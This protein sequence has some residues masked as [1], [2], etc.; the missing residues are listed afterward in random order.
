M[1]SPA[2]AALLVRPRTAL[3]MTW[4]QSFFT[5]LVY[6]AVAWLVT[7]HEFFSYDTGL[8]KYVLAGVAVSAALGSIILPFYLVSDAALAGRLSRGISVEQLTERRR[9]DFE[10][11]DRILALTPVDRKLLGLAYW[12]LGRFVFLGALCEAVAVIGLAVA[13]LEHTFYAVIPF[14]AGAAILKMTNRPDINAILAR[15][16]LFFD[17]E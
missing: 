15:G 1:N 3:T 14:V 8:L 13:I 4:A 16:R 7:P 12:Y 11:R 17:P 2:L 9:I 5:M 10:T 6:C